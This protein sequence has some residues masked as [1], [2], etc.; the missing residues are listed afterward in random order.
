MAIGDQMGD[1]AIQQVVGQVLQM[2]PAQA[3]DAAAQNIPLIIQALKDE[4]ILTPNI[5][6][7]TLATVQHE[8]AGTFR[9][10]EEYGGRQQA[11]RLGYSGGT[12]YFGRGFVQLTH[13]YNYDKYGKAI[14]MG[15]ALVKNP[16]LATDPKI[17]AKLLANYMKQSG[18]AQAA[19]RGDFYNAR[20]GVNR[21]DY[22]T[23]AP[24]ANTAGQYK[25]Y[26]DPKNI[27]DIDRAKTTTDITDL[28]GGGAQTNKGGIPGLN[29]NLQYPA[30]AISSAAGRLMS[31][32]AR[33]VYAAETPTENVSRMASTITGPKRSYTQQYAEEY[34]APYTVR[35]G[36]TLWSI[37][38]RTLGSGEKW[39]QLGYK[40]DPRQLQPG[41]SIRIPTP[42]RVSR[43]ASSQMSSPIRPPSVSRPSVSAPSSPIRSSAP[44]SPIRP[45]P[46][47]PRGPSPAQVTKSFMSSPIRPP[48]TPARNIAPSFS[49][50]RTS[51][52]S[53][54]IRSTPVM[55][56]KPAP[57]S[58]IKSSG[59]GGNIVSRL[60]NAVTN[61]FRR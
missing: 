48:A 8:T 32:V 12:E 47:P 16:S 43:P 59:G 53:S 6:A 21:H 15:D 18:T 51:A 44:S 41:T 37:A 46:T 4:G 25:T 52:P 38:E 60:V 30:N 26:I 54:Q 20:A 1:S 61:L 36:D 23:Y 31:S 35:S 58:P 17:A 45:T 27:S 24:I 49:P 40:G 13:D 7:Y 9:P 33:P 5:L 34:N 39:K 28:V 29:M 3:R 42:P 14:G 10:L 57:A 11:A 56:S 2:V 50:P 19:D 22:K 55:Q